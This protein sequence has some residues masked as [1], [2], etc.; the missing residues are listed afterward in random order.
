MSSRTLAALLLASTSALAAPRGTTGA[1][2]LQLYDPGAPDKR[3]MLIVVQVDPGSPAER[4]GVRVGDLV[5]AIDGKP[6]QG[7]DLDEISKRDLHG[8]PGA[9][10]KLGLFRLSTQEPV[11]V[12]V[13]RVAYKPLENPASDGFHYVTPGDWHSE[14]HAFPLQWAPQ[15]P[16]R[17]T[18]DLRFAPE[19][20]DS[21]AD[22][23]ASYFFV[24]WLDGEPHFDARRLEG[25]LVTYYR[26]L[27]TS[28]GREAGGQ[29][30]SLEQEPDGTFRGLV[31]S[32]D[33]QGKVE[34]RHGEV[35]VLRCGSHT[36][37]L[38]SV[39]PQDRGAAIWQQLDQIRDSFRCA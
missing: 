37:V 39:S 29:R 5:R 24:W 1:G 13:E 2:F 35:K 21:K 16:Y 9:L 31:T 34:P 23:Y 32:F 28:M 8:P 20:A 12:G 17:G 25:D 33:P 4:A 3:G 38:F 11:E 27:N 19:F 26:G 7:R 10:L 22:G 30:A 18:L 36:A 6:V 14:R 15:L